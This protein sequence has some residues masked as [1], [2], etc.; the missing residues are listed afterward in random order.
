MGRNNLRNIP[1]ITPP[2]L[3][4]ITS[5]ASSVPPPGM[6]PALLPTSGGSYIDPISSTLFSLSTNPYLIGIFMILLNLGGRFLPL[7]LTKNQEAFLQSPIVRPLILFTVI[8]IATRN[9]AVAFWLTLAI[10]SILWFLANE[11]SDWCIIPGWKEVND[12]DKEK[13]YQENIKKLNKLL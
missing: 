6:P 4:N 8:F 10:F 9:L 13:I 7:E 5:S 11:K 3:P 2:P 12:D 1:K